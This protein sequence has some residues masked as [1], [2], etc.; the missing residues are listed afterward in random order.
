LAKWRC[1]PRQ[2]PARRGSRRPARDT[3][4]AGKVGKT[5]QKAATPGTRRRR[6]E[7]AFGTSRLCGRVGTTFAIVVD[8]CYLLKEVT[9]RPCALA[10]RIFE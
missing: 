2:R 5:R 7:K 4:M 1:R 3:R 8:L 9:R 10:R 6:A